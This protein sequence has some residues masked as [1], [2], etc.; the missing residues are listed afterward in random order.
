MRA[1]PLHNVTLIVNELLRAT[2]SEAFSRGSMVFKRQ[3]RLQQRLC[4]QDTPVS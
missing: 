3:R 2:G 1:F 4:F